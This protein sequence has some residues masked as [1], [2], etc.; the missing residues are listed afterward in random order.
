MAS[1]SRFSRIFP[2][3]HAPNVSHVTSLIWICGVFFSHP[4][5]SSHVMEA[6]EGKI[7]LSRRTSVW[8]A[9]VFVLQGRQDLY[10]FFPNSTGEMETHTCRQIW[11]KGWV[12]RSAM[13]HQSKSNSLRTIKESQRIDEYMNTKSVDPGA[14]L[15]RFVDKAVPCD[16]TAKRNSRPGV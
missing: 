11:I 9:A 6:K 14:K 7:E 13:V 16:D 12:S 1:L 10:F 8:S 4:S 3:L 15:R 2:D 5:V